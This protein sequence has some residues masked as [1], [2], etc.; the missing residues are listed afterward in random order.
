MFLTLTNSNST[1]PGEAISINMSMV[2]TMNRAIVPQE[3]G[4]ELAKTYLFI[5]P[6]GTWEVKETLG[7]I[8]TMLDNN[9]DNIE[10]T[11][12]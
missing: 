4:T 6:H 9:S 2:V 11:L 8:M 7:E 12:G 10:T 3:D 5:P 1:Q